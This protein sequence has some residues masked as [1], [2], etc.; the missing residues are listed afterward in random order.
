MWAKPFL[1]PLDATP[2][3]LV[4]T[5]RRRVVPG[6]DCAGRGRH[7]HGGLLT[8]RQQL[9]TTADAAVDAET[10]VR[11]RV[12]KI[13]TTVRL[14]DLPQGLLS[15]VGPPQA[16]PNQDAQDDVS[17][18]ATVDED[19]GPSY[20]TVVSQA[21]RNM[22]KFSNCVLLTRVGGF[23]ELYFEHAEEYGRLL[24]LKVAQ[25]KT[26]AGSV[27]MVNTFTLFLPSPCLA[28]C[29]VVA[30]SRRSLISCPYLG[31]LSLLP[32]G[33]FPQNPRSRPEPLCRRCRGVSQ[34]G[35]RQGQVGR[36]AARPQGRPHH[37]ARDPDRRE[38]YGSVCK[39]LRFGHP[40]FL[41][42]VVSPVIDPS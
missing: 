39:Q 15:P 8:S 13:R 27:P 23:Y 3:L 1:V 5:C 11:K 6:F 14:E 30:A 2:S 19:E 4:R 18:A 36:P 9:R 32:A 42:Y 28:V 38:L 35:P 10:G 22:N 16:Q 21:R 20:P 7:G 25:K 31:R 41:E 34:H 37:H 40:C 29:R 17:A 12:R 26:S 24:N 33:P